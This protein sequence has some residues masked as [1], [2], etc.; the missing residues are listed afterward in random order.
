ML[1]T[2]NQALIS[3]LLIII[4]VGAFVLLIG[5]TA[6]VEILKSCNEIN[7]FTNIYGKTYTCYRG[8]K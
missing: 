2:L 1:N 6:E 5:Y 4:F 3:T 8:E 7:S